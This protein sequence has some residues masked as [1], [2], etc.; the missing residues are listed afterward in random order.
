MMGIRAA[1]LNM[2]G[3][4][5]VMVF[6]TAFHQT[7]PEKAYLYAIPRVLYK[8]TKCVV[9]VPMVLPMTT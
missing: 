1:E 4:P 8:N 9:T 5:Q 3:V 7:M 2:P 6:D